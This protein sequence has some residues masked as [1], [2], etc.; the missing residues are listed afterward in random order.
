MGAALDPATALGLHLPRAAHRGPA[1]EPGILKKA[2][3]RCS[4]PPDQCATAVALPPGATT[5][6]CGGSAR[7]WPYRPAAV[8]PGSLRSSG[9]RGPE[10]AGLGN[11]V[12]PG[13]WLP[14]TLRWPPSA[15]RGPASARAPGGPPAPAYGP[16]APGPARAGYPGPT[17]A[18]PP[19]PAL[20]PNRLL[21]QPRPSGSGSRTSR[22]CSAPVAPWACSCAF[23][24]VTSKQVLGGHV[25]ATMPDELVTPALPRALLA[26]PPTPELSGHAGRGNQ[27]RS[28]AYQTRLH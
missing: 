21:A 1:Q 19:G 9:R 13:C 15:S 25:A 8:R 28:N 17:P 22:V 3:A 4:Q 2:A 18:S 12:A 23:Q 6:P 27:Y 16:A 10:H 5:P 7:Y 11:G 20:R 24:D 26:H 14:Q